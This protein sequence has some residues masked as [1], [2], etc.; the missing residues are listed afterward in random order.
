[1]KFGFRTF[2]RTKINNADDCAVMKLDI[3]D[4]M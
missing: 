3:N 4:I 1:M 2:F